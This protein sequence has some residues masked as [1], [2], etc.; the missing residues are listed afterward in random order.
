M[1]VHLLEDLGADLV[2]LD[3]VVKEPV[4]GGD[5]DGGVD[6]LLAGKVFDDQA[7]VRVGDLGQVAALVAE[8]L[9]HFLDRVPPV[10]DGLP[11]HASQRLVGLAQLLF[12]RRQRLLEV[13]LLAAQFVPLGLELKLG[14]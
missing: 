12:E 14:Y 4:A 11:G 2:G 13:H 5:L 1:F 8:D 6:T 7:V 3:N 10:E 9:Q